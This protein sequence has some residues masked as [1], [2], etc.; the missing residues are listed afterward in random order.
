MMDA[1]FW[2][3]KWQINQI[4]FHQPKPNALLVAHLGE[5]TLSAGDRVFVP[6]CGKTLDIPYLLSRGYRV[7]GAELSEIAVSQLFEE[8]AVTPEITEHGTLRC[9][10]ADGIDIFTGDIFDLGTELLGP[11]DAIFDRAALVALPEEM[12]VRYSKLLASI[13]RKA[14]QLLITFEY[15]QTEM[16]GPPFS[17]SPERV[18]A[19][20]AGTYAIRR[21]AAVEVKGGLKGFCP[22]TEVMWLLQFSG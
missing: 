15:D 9:Y 4:A 20:Y 17:I 10:R 8:M 6:L 1:N 13:T 22:A 7:A 2:H 3:E 11:V 19:Y 5:L 18:A 16:A 21:L 14:P 12:R